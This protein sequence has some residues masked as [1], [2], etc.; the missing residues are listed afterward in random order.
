MRFVRFWKALLAVC[1][2]PI[3]AEPLW[4]N[5]PDKLLVDISGCNGAVSA[6]AEAPDGRI[7]LAGSFSVCGGIA[8]EGVAVYDPLTARFAPLGT[9]VQCCVHALAFHRGELYAGGFFGRAGSAIVDKV[10]RWDGTRWA[11][12]GNPNVPPVFDRRWDG[13]VYALVEYQGQLYAAGAFD[14]IGNTLA[15]NVA[16][17]DGT[18]WTE[19]PLFGNTIDSVVALAV[20]QGQLYAGGF[21]GMIPGGG[22]FRHIARFDGT[23]WRAVGGGVEAAAPRTDASVS[24]LAVHDGALY[25]GGRFARAGNV[26]ASGLARWEGEQWSPVGGGIASGSVRALTSFAG[27]LVAGGSFELQQDGQ[28][29][30]RLAR[31]NG[32]T[33]SR[34]GTSG[35]DTVEAWVRALHASEH[36]LY[37]GGEFRQVDRSLYSHVASWNTRE[38]RPLGSVSASGIAGYT[39]TLALSGNTLYVGGQFAA[40]GGVPARSIARWNGSSWAS[41]PGPGGEGVN[42]LV[43]AIAVSGTDVY[44]GGY[45]TEAAGIAANHIARWDG[46]RWHTLGEGA[47][48]GVDGPVHLIEVAPDGIYVGGEFQRA[49]GQPARHLAVWRDGRWESF[50]DG[51]PQPV[52][53]LAGT[54]SSIYTSGASS[55]TPEAHV[56]HWNGQSWTRI[57]SSR[58]GPVWSLVM[59]RGRP[60]ISFLNAVRAWDGGSWQ[61]LPEVTDGTPIIPLGLTVHRDQLH[62]TGYFT[63]QLPGTPATRKARWD[64][65]RWLPFWTEQPQREAFRQLASNGT[66]LVDIDSDGLR[67]SPFPVLHS[68]SVDSG[69]AGGAS[70]TPTVARNGVRL[71]FASTAADLVSG[72]GNGRS[73]IY[74]RDPA[75][76]QTERISDRVAAL[77]PAATEDYSEP[78]LSA[79]G[80]SIVF[81]GS[82]GQVWAV[83]HGVPRLAS[84]NLAGAPG[85]GPSQ[86]PMLAGKGRYLVFESRADNLV[87]ADGNG[88]VSDIFRK[89]LET[90]VV[91]LVSVG[92]EGEAGNGPS[93]TPWASDDGRSVAF[94]SSATNLTT[95][96]G[97][98]TAQAVLLRDGE[99]PQRLLLS[100]NLATG[101]AGNGPSSDVRITPDGRFGVFASSASNLVADDGNYASDIFFFEI[102][103]AGVTRLERLSLSIYREEGNAGSFAPSIRDD[104]GL[105]VFATDASN[106]VELDS[107]GQRDVLLKDTVSRNVQ[108][109]SRSADGLQPNGASD[110]PMLSGDGSA[111]V[112]QSAARNLVAADRD[113]DVD[114]YAVTL[115]DRTPIAI[116]TPLDEPRVEQFVLPAPSPPNGQCPGGFF[117][118]MIT[119]GPGAGVTPGLF[120]VELLLDEPGTRTLAG[121][122]NFGGTADVDQAG[123]AGFNIANAAN[124]PQ[125]FNLRVTGNAI[126]DSESSVPVR[127]RVARRTATSSD[128]LY[129]TVTTVSR[130]QAHVHSL[131]LPPAFYEVT[132]TPQVGAPRGDADADFFVEATTSF[133]DRPG[134]GFQG[135]AVVG[136]YHSAAPGNGTSGFAGFCLATPHT[137]SVRVLSRPSYGEQGARDLRLRLLDGQLRS[138][139]VMPME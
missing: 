96:P 32:Q 54:G 81:S 23:Q 22:E 124:E 66:S 77:Q 84:S 25:V 135:G 45:F 3:C 107:N 31:W 47:S 137:T 113:A 50:G 89:D 36:Q 42:S 105:V 28:T 44:V 80:A 85:N 132:V 138:I 1:L 82:A 15:T 72:G 16:R 34:A 83:I 112:F 4:A 67:A 131:V 109:L 74:L 64:G 6:I 130:A 56:D 90:G 52:G 5:G 61:L 68:V 41:L 21:S 38:W 133:V 134:G 76:G 125:R 71:A 116:D 93:S 123:F 14:N 119:D 69:A 94:I 57:F 65:T 115:V 97:N 48:N 9:G 59:F 2:A 19:L 88:S 46:S 117:I 110:R 111:I 129:E 58:F 78:S 70:T 139:G 49:G 62:A 7:Y 87:A 11:S 106:L 127:I 75:S 114:V 53:A 95:T 98:G 39:E 13:P 29:I 43:T 17:W 40:A 63:L 103:S 10:A 24:A 79:D 35:E 104:G 101:E 136:G 37:A 99:T 55:L 12:V 126:S 128:T 91:T 118:A 121:G 108:R 51:P 86:R 30:R 8:T 120:G 18:Q 102:G 60:H 100:R 26:A 92:A 27:A 73:H 20:F 122:L 33:W